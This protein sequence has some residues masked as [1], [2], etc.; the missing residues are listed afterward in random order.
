M[1]PRRTLTS[2][3]AFTYERHCCPDDTMTRRKTLE[4]K[5][6]WLLTKKTSRDVCAWHVCHNCAVGMARCCLP[7][8]H[9]P[10]LS[11]SDGEHTVG[12]TSHARRRRQYQSVTLLSAPY[13]AKTARFRHYRQTPERRHHNALSFEYHIVNRPDCHLLTC[14]VGWLFVNYRYIHQHQVVWRCILR[15]QHRRHY[16]TPLR[17][18]IRRYWRCRANI[19]ATPDK[20]RQATAVNG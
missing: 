18:A 4:E 1:P 8:S 13:A 3:P 16:G 10:P 6:H 14:V 9:T 5:T 7:S 2:P 19:V 15:A 11:I 12:I 17:A 20:D